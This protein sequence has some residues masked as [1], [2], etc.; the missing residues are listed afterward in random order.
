M[1]NLIEKLLEY[2]N[3]GEGKYFNPDYDV[4]NQL[5][6]KVY[7]A[8]EYNFYP[9]YVELF[10]SDCRSLKERLGENWWKNPFA[11]YM[12]YRKFNIKDLRVK[13]DNFPTSECDSSEYSMKHIFKIDEAK[14]IIKEQPWLTIEKNGK[15]LFFADTLTPAWT[16]LRSLIEYCILVDKVDIFEE[17]SYED[18]A[19]HKIF[20]FK[21]PEEALRELNERVEKRIGTSNYEVVLC[22][23]IIENIVSIIEMFEKYLGSTDDLY[24][25]INLSHS[26]SGCNFTVVPREL[27]NRSR[28]P[29]INR[30][31]A[32]N[33]ELPNAGRLWDTV[34]VPIFFVHRWYMKNFDK[35]IVTNK[36]IEKQDMDLKMLAKF[37]KDKEVKNLKLWLKYYMDRGGY[38]TFIED[39]NFESC[40]YEKDSKENKLLEELANCNK[41]YSKKYGFPIELFKGHLYKYDFTSGIDK[42]ITYGI[43]EADSVEEDFPLIGYVNGVEDFK[44]IFKMM[45]NMF[46]KRKEKLA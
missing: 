24:A 35:E 31:V 30:K 44:Q 19:G 22:E 25:F 16:I 43:Y 27:L 26:G 2:N 6:S 28:D 1:K 3:D 23:Y 12:L 37:K 38:D 4:K 46:E 20:N 15:T 34:D 32:P 7:I 10:E 33:L 14:N 8:K 45:K 39:Y 21:V 42:A 9:K 40:V 41:N 29:F 11:R 13:C 17:D 36:Y 18:L 5:F